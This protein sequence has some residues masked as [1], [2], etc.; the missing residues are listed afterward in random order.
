MYVIHQLYGLPLERTRP[1]SLLPE[2][3][4]NALRKYLT[5]NRTPDNWDPFEGLVMYFQLID[6]SA[7]IR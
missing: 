5:S 2:R 4:L 1:D 6:A 7:G 3:R